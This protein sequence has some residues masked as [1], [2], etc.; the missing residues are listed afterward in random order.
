MLRV[1]VISVGS[2]KEKYLQEMVAEY[3][4]RLQRYC[5][6]EQIQLDEVKI[7]NENSSGEIEKALKV[8][9]KKIEAK[10]TGKDFL[11]TLCVEGKQLKSEEFAETLS[12]LP[13]KGYSSVAF[14]IGSSHGLDEELKQKSNLKLSFSKMTFPHQLMRGILLEQIYRAFQIS[15]GGKY[16]K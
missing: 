3:T 2:L 1:K 11:I 15:T 9:R 4:K 12:S 5:V 6:L 7:Q 16:H 10:L 8:E 13:E 14:V